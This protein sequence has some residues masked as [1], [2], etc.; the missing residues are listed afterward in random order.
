MR[1]FFAMRSSDA[2]LDF[3]MDLAKKESNENPV[4]YVQYAHARICT[5]LKSAKEK[6]FE[7]DLNYLAEHLMS[8][9]ALDLLK[10]LGDFP[11]VIVDA[12][13]DRAPHRM[14][15]YVFDLASLL[16]SYYNAEK[17]LDLENPDKTKARLAL[18]QAVRITIANALK[19]IGVNAPDQM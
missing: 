2:H 10:Q 5:L 17:V 6:G 9:K 11:Q 15:Q 8:E 12:A 13:Q 14:T 1:Y 16:H 4:F 18:M 3:D 19:L 7:A